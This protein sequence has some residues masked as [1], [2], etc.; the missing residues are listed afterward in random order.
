MSKV[1]EDPQAAP[2]ARPSARYA[3]LLG[4]S[5]AVAALAVCAHKLRDYLDRTRCRLTLNAPE[6]LRAESQ[7]RDAP[8]ARVWGVSLPLLL[9]EPTSEGT[10]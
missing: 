8:L 9:E 1:K 4:V 5:F 6:V 10:G 3:L 2:A 7:L